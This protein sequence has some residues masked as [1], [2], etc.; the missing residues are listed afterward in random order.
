MNVRLPGGTL[1]PE[2]QRRYLVPVVP[3]TLYQ[4]W[5]TFF[6]GLPWYAY[7]I[8]KKKCLAF[9]EATQCRTP[10]AQLASA[11]PDRLENAPRPRLRPIQ[12]D[13]WSLRAGAELCVEPARWRESC[14]ENG[15]R[16]PVD[17]NVTPQATRASESQ[18]HYSSE[19]I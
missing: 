17:V 18:R 1:Y 7:W 2:G 6:C 13:T 12:E 11:D 14:C 5:S 9:F 15:M 16:T 19:F 10:P 8:K 3:V 4:A